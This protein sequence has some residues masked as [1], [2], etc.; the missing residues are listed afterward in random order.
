LSGSWRRRSECI[1]SGAVSNEQRDEVDG[2][3]NDKDQSEHNRSDFWFQS[4][5]R[6]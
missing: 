2:V 4:T 1:T 3:M 5:K 6:P